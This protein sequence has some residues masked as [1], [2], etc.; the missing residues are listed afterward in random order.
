MKNMLFGEIPSFE[1]I[2]TCIARLEKEI[3][4]L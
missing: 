2:M 4:S 3:N 1:E